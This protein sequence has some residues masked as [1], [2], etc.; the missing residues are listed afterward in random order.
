MLLIYSDGQA[1]Y[2]TILRSLSGQEMKRV[3][4]ALNKFSVIVIINYTP[5]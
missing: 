3:R 2:E 1:A 5:Y 4:L